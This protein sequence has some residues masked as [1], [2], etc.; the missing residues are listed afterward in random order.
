[1]LGGLACDFFVQERRYGAAAAE[2]REIGLVYWMPAATAAAD[3]GNGGDGDP[4]C[5]PWEFD[6]SAHRNL[7]ASRVC[8]YVGVA[9]AFIGFVA[10]LADL[11]LSLLGLG[12]TTSCGGTSSRRHRRILKVV[13]MVGYALAQAVMLTFIPLGSGYCHERSTSCRLG[14]GARYMIGAFA[15]FLVSIVLLPCSSTSRRKVGCCRRGR[16]GSG[17]T[18]LPRRGTGGNKNRNTTD[19]DNVDVTASEDDDFRDEPPGSG[20]IE[21]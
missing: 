15:C 12:S 7:Y 21:I 4:S 1:M 3:N 17:G 16:R 11:A 18:V 2:A 8:L 6:R 9:G 14:Q 20:T 10:V 5:V 19:G 13:A